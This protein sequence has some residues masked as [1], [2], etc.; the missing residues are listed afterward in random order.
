MEN[1]LKDKYLVEQKVVDSTANVILHSR[2]NGTL[3]TMSEVYPVLY[4]NNTHFSYMAKTRARL[5]LNNSFEFGWK[6]RE[7]HVF[8]SADTNPETYKASGRTLLRMH[9]VF[10]MLWHATELNV[11]VRIDKTRILITPLQDF[12]QEVE[13][14]IQRY[15]R[16][17]Y[18]SPTDAVL[19]VGG[20]Q[21]CL[22]NALTSLRD[23][24]GNGSNLD[25][26]I[27]AIRILAASVL[28]ACTQL[29]RFTYCEGSSRYFW[30]Q[31][32]SCWNLWECVEDSIC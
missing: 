10:L 21:S 24:K 11:D 30:D 25:D 16:F 9:T 22:L 7:K 14:F 1:V 27:A 17:V 6:D 32:F 31:Y 13:D 29:A 5:A 19:A 28:A 26:V 8:L 4:K 20:L 12:T 23:D 2:K 18:S 15:S 3:G